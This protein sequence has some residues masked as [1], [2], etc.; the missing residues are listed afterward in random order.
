MF[1]I[2]SYSYGRPK[3]TS[4]LLGLLFFV[5]HFLERS[6]LKH[7]LH[8]LSLD[9]NSFVCFHVPERKRMNVQHLSFWY[10]LESEMRTS[11]VALSHIQLDTPQIG[12]SGNR[13]S[14]Y[15]EKVGKRQ[16]RLPLKCRCLHKSKENKLF[17]LV[18]FHPCRDFVMERGLPFQLGFKE[19][20]RDLNSLHEQWV[21][22]T[23]D[24]IWE[25]LESSLDY[26]PPPQKWHDGF[27]NLFCRVP[28][29]LNGE[30]IDDI[31]SRYI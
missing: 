2:T 12:P 11:S 7:S 16:K 18:L 31:A 20:R 29:R 27:P 9:Q 24:P 19:K 17:T 30:K 13:T 1:S 6:I 25:V 8:I 3:K 10:N 26:R 28:I 23:T 4:T 5:S 21:F 22:S 14:K 15:F